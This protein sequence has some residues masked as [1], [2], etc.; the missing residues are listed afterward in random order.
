MKKQNKDSM[1]VFYR[2]SDSSNVKGSN[3]TRPP[4]FDKRKI[5]LD[6]LKVFDGHAVHIIADNVNDESATWLKSLGF[7]VEVTSIGT[8]DG[9]CLYAVQKAI[10]MCKPSDLVYLVEDDYVHLP[11]SPSIIEHGLSLADYVTLY[12]HPDK[13]KDGYN[14]YIKDN[15][16]VSLVRQTPDGTHW[17]FTN[18][19]TEPF[20]ARVS[21]LVRDLHLFNAILGDAKTLHAQQQSP[22]FVLWLNILQ[23]CKLASCMP[24]YA[25]HLHIPWVTVSPAI[26]EYIKKILN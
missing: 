2:Y 8:G 18:S 9:S 20:G 22:D 16:E 19:T 3:P 4:G 6:F 14:P 11:G 25:S 12:D 21:A 13:Y 17:K 7:D 10:S 26:E 23:K 5:L 24:G 1:H 15:G